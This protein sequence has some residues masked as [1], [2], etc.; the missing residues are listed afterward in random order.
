M[1]D[2]EP[3]DIGAEML[4]ADVFGAI[5]RVGGEGDVR[6]VRDLSP[7]RPW[8]RWLARRLAAREARALGAVRGVEGVPIL[9]G[10][11]GRRLER[12]WLGGRPM[13]VARPATRAYYREALGLLRRLH[14]RNVV[15]NDTAKEP[16]WLVREDG[17]PA[18]VD[19]QLAWAPGRR[20]ALFRLLAREDLRHL[21][22]HKRTYLP[23]ALTERQ[24]AMLATPAITARL[25]R[26][27]PKKLYLFFTRR[28][29]GWA[30]REGATDRGARP[31][32]R[33]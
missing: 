19:F 21:L 11:D 15:H 27:G 1:H 2:N 30:D 12:S 25:W 8:A 9:L 4:K 16:N 17:R 28:L 31:A 18:L 24:R 6:I 3:H 5:W 7:A 14:A 29:L 26:A 20:G 32:G 10:W 13:Q 22:K 33:D 23:Q